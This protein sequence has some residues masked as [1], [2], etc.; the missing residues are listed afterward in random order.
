MKCPAC[1]FNSFE[2]NDSCPRC[3]AGLKEVRQTYGLGIVVLSPAQ[4]RTLT[5]EY[6]SVPS[7]AET[8][9]DARM[10]AFE[11]AGAEQ[12]PA[13]QQTADADPFSFID[14]P[15]APTAEPP[16]P[17]NDPFADLLETTAQPAAAPA[18]ARGNELSSFSWD[19]TPS[20]ESPHREP[21]ASPAREDDFASLFGDL[22]EPRK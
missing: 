8:D 4:R 14:T 10:F 19:D 21:D 20:P 11:L 15:A 9:A 17:V 13:P 16:P 18:A 1:G 7:V 12:E 3:S 5:A 2:G 6:A 22:G